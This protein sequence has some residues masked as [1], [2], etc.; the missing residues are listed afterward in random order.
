MILNGFIT[1]TSD[2]DN[3]LGGFNTSNTTF[4]CYDTI[5]NLKGNQKGLLKRV[6]NLALDNE[7][8]SNLALD[9]KWHWKYDETNE[10][11]NFLIKQQLI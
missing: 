6:S 7:E 4:I 1:W 5:H 2:I 10:E 9:K 8:I 3:H 11:R